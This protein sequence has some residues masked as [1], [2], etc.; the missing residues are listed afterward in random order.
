MHTNVHVYK[1]CHP[2]GYVRLP[3][4]TRPEES[5]ME[6]KIKEALHILM[7]PLHQRLNRDELGTGPTGLL[8]NDDEADGRWARLPLAP[9]PGCMY[10]HSTV[11]P[12]S[13]VIFTAIHVASF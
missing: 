7:T 11:H 9:I 3:S 6:L 10:P 12:L 4:L 1:A 2:V 8:D 5:C 13:S